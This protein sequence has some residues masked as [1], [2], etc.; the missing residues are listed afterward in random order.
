MPLPNPFVPNFSYPQPY[1][2]GRVYNAYNA[3]AIPYQ[4]SGGSQP[5]AIP[6][7]QNG[8]AYQQYQQYQSQVQPQAQLQVYQSSVVSQPIPIAN[9]QN[10]WRWQQANSQP[11][12][13]QQPNSQQPNPNV[14]NGYPPY[15]A[16][17][18]AALGGQQQLWNTPP[19]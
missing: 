5:M 6:N 3:P 1:G 7:Y 8:Y 2:P 14:L 16:S 10:G 18:P 4:S 9:Y 17:R 15:Y 13:Q 19:R 12:I 11:P